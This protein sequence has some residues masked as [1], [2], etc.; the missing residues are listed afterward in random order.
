M[1][2]CSAERG[3]GEGIH[4]VGVNHRTL[5][6]ADRER[7]AAP[8]DVRVRILEVLC[9]EQ[10]LAEAAV[11][12]TCNRFE[13]VG[14][15]SGARDRLGALVR[16]RLGVPDSADCIYEYRN[17][18][19][20][21]HLFRVAAS[22]DSLVLGEA[23]ILGQV[24]E[25]YQEAVACGTIGS[26]LHRLFQCAFGF[27][28]KVRSRTAIGSHS[29]SVSYIAVQ[30]AK[31]IFGS[32]EDRRALLIG[33]GATAELAALHLRRA[34]CAGIV[35]AN[36]SVAH[37][38]ELAQRVGGSAVALSEL[39]RYLA[40]VD[41]AIGS[42][43]I[44]RPLVT[45]AMLERTRRTRPLFLIDLGV[46][47]NFAPTLADLEDV[48]LYN[49]DD[50][51][52]AAERHR[53]IREEVAQDAE[54]M[55]EYALMQFERRLLRGHDQEGIVKLRS[56]VQQICL[57]ELMRELKQI[58]PEAACEEVGQRLAHRVSQKISHE[59]LENALASGKGRFD[60]MALL[61]LFID[62]LLESGDER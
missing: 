21:R 47:R 57:S 7:L 17:A 39:E 34:G 40:E 4:L 24:K 53:E 60:P 6:V 1:Q 51:Q 42:I 23:Q 33:S 56:R 54:L 16:E 20:V 46:P 22:L 31:Q 58:L 49:I 2:V 19:A 62:E 38:E 36:R 32:L 41:V 3:Y 8:R 13:I 61:P 12:S 44:D 26:Y 48:Y 11:L 37:A 18:E 30:L 14:V 55:V 59:L 28:K 15:G 9:R 29:I 43:S 25:A 5:A 35:V 50:L 10:G 45:P 27:A 52:N